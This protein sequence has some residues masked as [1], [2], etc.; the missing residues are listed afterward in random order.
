MLP[1]IESKQN[2]ELRI[3]AFGGMDERIKIDNTS[4]AFMHNI[5]SEEL[6]AL[7]PR[8]G[9]MHIA[10]LKNA[11]CICSPEY[12]G[13]SLT[14][15]TGIADRKFYY[16]GKEISGKLSEGRKSVADFNGKI[17]IF[18]D[19]VYYDYLPDGDTGEIKSELV[20]MEK[21][22]SVS[23]A[24]FY[25]SYN[26]I[27]GEYSA[28]IK[29]SGT[30]FSEC[31]AE[32]DSIVIS[33]CTET[34]NNTVYLQSRKQIVS[35]STIVSAV[36]ESVENSKLNLVLYN[37][38]G[39]KV[40][41]VNTSESKSITLKKAIPDMDNICVH[42]N[43]LWGTAV[44]GEYI[45]ASKLGDC[46]NFNSFQGLSD[47]SWYSCIGT[48]GN[49]TGIC[50][51]R[52]AVVAFKKN[53]IHHIYG[54]APNNFSIPKQTYGGCTDGRSICEISGVLY[55]LSDNG[56]YAYS[57][58]EPYSV[59]P[60]IKNRYSSCS[61]GT[62]GKRYFASAKKPTGECDVL[63]Y[64][65]EHNVW[66]REDDAEFLSM[67]CYNGE[68]YAVTN[69]EMLK[70]KGGNE[71]VSWSL[72]SKNFTFND[73]DYKGL[74]CI[75]LRMELCDEASVDV[76]VS[77]DGGDFEHCK[78][79]EAKNRLCV[80]KVP[81]RFGKCDGFKVMLRG[82]GYA[83]LDGIEFVTYKGGRIYG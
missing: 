57:G 44:S 53:C 25:S 58:G 47:D 1:K 49:F 62:D 31:F 16:N 27:N 20:S 23:G 42:N 8:S 9:R 75:W 30:E 11:D 67:I 73:A 81:V 18:P 55:Y 48:G 43:R 19:K 15:F 5:S 37:K 29:A 41:F 13:G 61:A 24:E 83:V 69:C 36:V 82:N 70:M 45:Y 26:E 50:S 46:T 3:N 66:V 10:D 64:S 34:S 72:V 4:F 68:M 17:C 77:K 40:K 33:D 2:K 74:D 79:L 80:Y 28:Y 35:A 54:D 59:S 39:E 63:V 32:G 22:V 7:T 78:S 71:E 21:N 12:T 65:P 38:T 56:F 14:G 52:T 6:P 51:Y 76:Y 60:Q